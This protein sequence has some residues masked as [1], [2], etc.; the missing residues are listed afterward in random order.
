[1]DGVGSTPDP[2]RRLFPRLGSGFSV[3]PIGC[4]ESPERLFQRHRAARD[5]FRVIKGIEAN[6]PA[7]GGVDMTDEE[8]ATFEIVLAAPH[9]K[10]RKS[11][12]QTERMLAAVRHPR[13]HVLAHPRG[14]MD[15]R[16]GVLAR[17]DEVFEEAAKRDVAIEL[18]GDPYRQDLDYVIAR[19]AMKAGCLFALDSDAHSGRELAYA[20]LAIAHARLAGIPAERVIN[21][22]PAESLLAWAARKSA[23]RARRRHAPRATGQPLRSVPPESAG[24]TPPT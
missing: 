2:S 23:G 12:D 6:I 4:G 19:R 7:G 13:V 14:R 3:R 5:G 21:T 8:L 9:S 17:W 20:E 16:Q 22:W 10:L 18:D 1:M 11:E 24:R 15:S